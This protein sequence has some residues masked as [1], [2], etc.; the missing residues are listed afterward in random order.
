[1]TE[2]IITNQPQSQS[3]P[4]TM[5]HEEAIGILSDECHRG[6]VTFNSA[7][8]CALRMAIVALIAERLN[9]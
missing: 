1:M 2:I 7:H 3:E 5:S 6:C 8:R 4:I 9:L